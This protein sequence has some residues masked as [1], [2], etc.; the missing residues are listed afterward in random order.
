[1]IYEKHYSPRIDPR[2]VVYVD[3]IRGKVGRLGLRKGDIITHV[4]DMDWTGNAM[5]LERHLFQIYEN[6]PSDVISVTV[7]ASPETAKFLK[8]RA[9][10]LEK[11]RAELL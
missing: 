4:N 2:P 11:A 10:M 5:Q 8:V 6:N 3:A 7:N 9:E 1:M